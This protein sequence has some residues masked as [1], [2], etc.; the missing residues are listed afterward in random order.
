LGASAAFIAAGFLWDTDRVI[1]IDT[2]TNDAMSEG[3]R[4]TF[5]EF[6]ANTAKHQQ[7]IIP[8]RGWS[9]DPAVLSQ[10]RANISQINLLFI[11][12]DHSYEGA[13]ADWRLY[14]PL[15]CKG[16]IVVMHDIGWAEGVQRV[17]EE[18]IRPLVEW[19]RRLSNM[20]WGR[21]PS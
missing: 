2:W 21:M 18:E 19:E 6:L 11:D 15:L 5:V 4:D 3:K 17:V 1:C 7:R 9:H 20:W 8:I 16:A 13:L 14:G 12:G 10:V